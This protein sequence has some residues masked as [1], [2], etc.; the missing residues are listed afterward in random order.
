MK[1]Y[2]FLSS[3]IRTRIIDLNIKYTCIYIYIYIYI[4]MYIKIYVIKNY[5][6]TWFSPRDSVFSQYKS[7][8]NDAS[9]QPGHP[10]LIGLSNKYI[11][12]YCSF[13]LIS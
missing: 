9:R 12:I 13:H 7:T 3:R 1:N 6:K 5:I 11:T 8:S 2:L 4:Y 10:Q